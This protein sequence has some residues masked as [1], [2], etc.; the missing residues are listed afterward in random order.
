MHGGRENRNFVDVAA[1][2]DLGRNRKLLKV[3]G[4]SPEARI[5]H[6]LT[7][8]EEIFHG[9]QGGWRWGSPRVLVDLP[10]K[11]GLGVLLGTGLGSWSSCLWFSAAAGQVR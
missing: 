11:R 8:A 6:E 2:I 1:R 5:D 10:G 4:H 7:S 9:G 3:L